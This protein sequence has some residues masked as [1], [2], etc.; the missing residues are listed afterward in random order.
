MS[1]KRQILE[2]LSKGRITV[3]EAS[4]LLDA[5]SATETK[6][7]SSQTEA[8]DQSKKLAKILQILVHE[9]DNEKINV[10]VP[11][12]LAKFAARFIP[13]TAKVKLNDEGIDLKDFFETL[14]QQ[15]VR[16]GTLLDVTTTDDD[17]KLLHLK[18]EAS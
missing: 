14:R 2:L 7:V 12:G 11:M 6:D 5:I 8:A 1:E 10:S 16:V 9:E 15:E 3:D 4:D 13:K 18:I 17:G